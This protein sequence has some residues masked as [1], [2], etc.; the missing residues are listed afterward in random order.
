MVERINLGLALLF[1][2][3]LCQWIQAE[4]CHTPHTFQIYLF[5]QLYR[6]YEA[7]IGRESKKAD[8]S[9]MAANLMICHDS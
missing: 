7:E 4:I 2:G 8:T 3:C 9:T 1:I 5:S 6:V